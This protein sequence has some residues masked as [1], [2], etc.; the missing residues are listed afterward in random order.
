MILRPRRRRT[1]SKQSQ[2]RSVTS[3]WTKRSSKQAADLSKPAERA[4]NPQLWVT[5]PERARET[6]PLGSLPGPQRRR[7]VRATCTT[8]AHTTETQ[9]Q[10]WTGCTLQRQE[11]EG[12]QERETQV[13]HATGSYKA[14]RGACLFDHFVAHDCLL[15]GTPTDWRAHYLSPSPS[16]GLFQNGQAIQNQGTNKGS[17]PPHSP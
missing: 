5:R 7:G 2:R 9:T 14:S 3:P 13:Q 10:R 15:F 8:F 11:R 6:S 1:A 16:S 4:A 12:E 17:R